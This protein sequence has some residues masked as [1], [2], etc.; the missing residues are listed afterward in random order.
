MYNT[1]CGPSSILKNQIWFAFIINIISNR[2]F[3]C[4]QTVV[5]VYI[6]FFFSDSNLLFF[7]FLLFI[8]YSTN[9]EIMTTEENIQSVELLQDLGINAGD[10]NKLKSAGI[11]SIA[12]CVFRKM[13]EFAAKY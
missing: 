2:F 13:F 4:C 9:K 1:T 5:L 6:Y 10:I 11:C 8:S 12:V 7:F 3:W